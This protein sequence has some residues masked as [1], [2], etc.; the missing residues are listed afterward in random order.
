[1]E[2]HRSQAFV[3]RKRTDRLD[4]GDEDDE[5]LDEGGHDADSALITSPIS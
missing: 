1:M 4:L 3:T 5:L 2:L